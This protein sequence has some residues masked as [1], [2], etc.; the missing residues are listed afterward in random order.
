MGVGSRI[1]TRWSHG[2]GVDHNQIRVAF[3]EAI[4]F[5]LFIF[6]LYTVPFYIS[7]P[8]QPTWHLQK[9]LQPWQP[10]REM[11]LLICS[12]TLISPA[13]LRQ[14]SSRCRLAHLGPGNTMLSTAPLLFMPNAADCQSDFTD[15]LI[16]CLRLCSRIFFCPTDWQKSP[17]Y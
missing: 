4:R 9:S 5:K 16:I 2:N 7:M 15:W 14:S 1:F 8:T 10:S 17:T 6:P 13:L 11:K 12:E 3:S